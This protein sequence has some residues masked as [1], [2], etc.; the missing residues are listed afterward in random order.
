MQLLSVHNNLRLLWVPGHCGFEGNEMA[1][2]LAEQACAYSFTGPSQFLDVYNHA[3]SEQIIG[4]G[5]SKSSKSPGNKTGM[6]TN[7]I[8]GPI[9]IGQTLAWPG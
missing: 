1:D 8:I 5:L 4:N 9:L 6:H 2:L 3:L 7:Q